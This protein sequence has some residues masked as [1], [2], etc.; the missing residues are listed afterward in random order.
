MSRG[1]G[2]YEVSTRGV[3]IDAV[4]YIRAVVAERVAEVVAARYADLTLP[5]LRVDL[6]VSGLRSAGVA[7]EWHDGDP[8]ILGAIPMD[9]DV[10]IAEVPLTS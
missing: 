4:G 6:S 7:V 9:S 3:P 2:E 5:L 10:V 8:R 1:F